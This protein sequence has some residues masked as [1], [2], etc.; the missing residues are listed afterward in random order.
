MIYLDHA[1]TS[2]PKPPAVLA[3]VQRWYEQLGVSAERG[4][5]GRCVEVRREVD[6]ARRRLGLLAGVAAARV[7]FTSGATESLNLALRA[8]LRPGDAVLT[9]VFEH[10]SVVRPLLALQRC[11]LRCCSKPKLSC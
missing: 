4:D 1:A 7:A 2:F 5:S 3:A 6:D 10:S 11:L 8:V 9:T